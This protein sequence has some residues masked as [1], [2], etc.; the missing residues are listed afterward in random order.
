MKGKLRL[1]LN[2]S[3]FLNKNRDK[4]LEFTRNFANELQKEVNAKYS[5]KFQNELYA[6]YS[7]KSSNKLEEKNSNQLN[8]ESKGQ[9]VEIFKEN[10]VEKENNSELELGRREGET[11]IVDEIGDDEKY[12]FLTRESDGKD[13]Q[14]FNISDELYKE[15]LND[16]REE[17]RVKFQ[18]GE[19]HII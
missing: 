12:V 14:E 18:N 7:N 2:L 13:F 8:D 1:D 4:L 9:F 16:T 5:N 11:Y 6:K 3:N 19:Y 15:L 17:L 10:E